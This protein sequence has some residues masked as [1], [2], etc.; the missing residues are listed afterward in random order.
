MITQLPADYQPDSARDFGQME[1]ALWRTS[2]GLASLR[3]LD[4]AA[5]Q[6]L[7][8]KPTVR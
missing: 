3:D 6:A 8:T 7:L 2:Q 4:D 5:T 1:Q